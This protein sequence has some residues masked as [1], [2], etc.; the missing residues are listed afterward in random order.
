MH[1]S[2]GNT[3]WEQYFS[4]IVSQGL[5]AQADRKYQENVV[6]KVEKLVDHNILGTCLQPSQWFFPVKE[7]EID[8]ENN[9]LVLGEI[10][11]TS[12]RVC[13]IIACIDLLIDACITRSANA[14][15]D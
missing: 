10:R 8:G 11:F 6:A 14:Q 12:P 15:E 3:S 5:S 7:E 1:S 2:F 4:M 9:R 13:A